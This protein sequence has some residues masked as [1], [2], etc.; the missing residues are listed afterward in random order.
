LSV[1]LTQ[2]IKVSALFV[3]CGFLEILVPQAFLPDLLLPQLLLTDLL[4]LFLALLVLVN[5][6]LIE[7]YRDTDHCK[8]VCNAVDNHGRIIKF[9]HPV[10]LSIFIFRA[11]LFPRDKLICYRRYSSQYKG[12]AVQY[13]KEIDIQ[14]A[15][16]LALR[17]LLSFFPELDLFELE[18]EIEDAHK[19]PGHA[20]VD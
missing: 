13:H 7:H 5:P 20:K 16:Y 12:Y 15:H 1:G 4:L 10:I 9:V 8:C 6:D 3:Q 19:Y 2:L 17:K 11:S 18:K 14:S